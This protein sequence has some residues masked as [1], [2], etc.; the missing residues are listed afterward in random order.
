M[1]FTLDGNYVNNFFNIGSTSTDLVYNVPV[2][3]N[4]SLSNKEHTLVIQATPGF[5]SA[6]TVLFDY[7][8]YT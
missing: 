5:Y 4:R 8:E 1:T 7:V 2:Y 6:S 3:A